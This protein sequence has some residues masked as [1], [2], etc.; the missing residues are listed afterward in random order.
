MHTI[1]RQNPLSK[2]SGAAFHGYPVAT[3]AYYGKDDKFATKAAVSILDE[4]D[5]V[6]SMERWY[7]DTSDVRTDQI[8]SQAIVSFIKEQRAKSVVIADRI[9]GCRHEEGID[10]PEGSVCL[11]CPFWKARDRWSGKIK[12]EG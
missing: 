10:Y 2:F 1:R 7:C 5:N 11:S 6:I 3:V 9:L 8:V 4:K 12:H